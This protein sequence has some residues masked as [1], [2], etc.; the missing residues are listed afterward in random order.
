MI[1]IILCDDQEIVTEGMQLI[2][3]SSAGIDVV[4][5]AHDG[6][7][8]VDLVTKLHPDLVLMDLR[9]PIMNGIHATRQIRQQFPDTK[10]LVLTTYDDDEWVFDAVR[11][12]AA[13]YLLKDAPREQIITSIKGTVAGLTHIDPKVAGKLFNFV[14]HP[15]S[16]ATT[17]SALTADLSQREI[18]I[19]KLIAD[20]LSN[21]DIADRLHLSKGTVQNYVSNIFVKLDVTDRTQAAIIALRHGLG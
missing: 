6:A 11:A 7:E 4:G 9:M 16:A 8:A 15:A 19:L 17:D 5:I 10:V 12:G 18:E 20:G 3:R 21:T 14:S 13:G 1:R 2:L